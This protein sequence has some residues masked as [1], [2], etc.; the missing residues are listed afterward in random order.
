[1]GFPTRSNPYPELV[2]RSGW[3][4]FAL[5]GVVGTLFAL[6]L[7]GA[8]SIGVLVLPIAA[9][10]AVLAARSLHGGRELLGMLAGAGAVFLLIGF[11]QLG[12]SPAGE[13]SLSIS[14]RSPGPAE[15]EGCDGFGPVPWL[16]T[17]GVLATASLAGYGIGR[18]RYGRPG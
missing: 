9:L 4:A 13:G 11:D 18:G 12:C 8:D 5:W 15:I 7:V 16:V 6:S 10:A 3:A 2:R 17:G 14:P 1:M